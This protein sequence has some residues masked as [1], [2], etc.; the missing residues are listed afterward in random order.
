[1]GRLGPGLLDHLRGARVLPRAAS[2]RPA[3]A[4]AGMSA[5]ASP[6]AS[7]ASVSALSGSSSSRAC[8]C[9]VSSTAR[10]RSASG[11]SM[12]PLRRAMAS[13]CSAPAQSAGPALQVEQRLDRPGELGI[14]PQ[15]A[16]G[17]LALYLVLALAAGFEKQPAQAELLGVR[18]SQHGFEDAPRRRLVARELR[19]LRAQQMRQRLV[20]QRLARLHGV[21]RRHGAVAGADGDHAAGQRVEAAPLTPPGQEV[22]DGGRARPDLAHDGP[23]QDREAEKHGEHHDSV[24]HAGRDLVVLPRD[25]QCARPVG[26]PRQAGR[27]QQNTQ[28]EQHETHHGRRSF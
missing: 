22:A 2:S 10:R 14:E 1:M 6:C 3:M 17:E 7:S 19:R 24:E 25:Q 13:V 5:G 28:K 26:E 16:L 23:G 21:A 27:Q 9:A 11:L 15:G 20:R 8:A 4:A 12:W 18:R